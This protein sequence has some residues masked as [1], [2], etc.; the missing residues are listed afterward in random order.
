MLR[1]QERT[2]EA[3]KQSDG[4]TKYDFMYA[5]F[6]SSYHLRDWLVSDGAATKDEMKNLFDSSIEL[7]LCRDIC[8]A[9]KHLQYDKPS[10]DA[11]PRISRE[12]DPFRN[13]DMGFSLYSD[14][15]RPIPELMA[16]CVKTWDDFLKNKGLINA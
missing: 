10:I 2:N 14:K 8:N 12:W 15:K 6:Q 4:K 9:T 11:K 1:W 3:L 5:F 13:K 16:Q 7:Q